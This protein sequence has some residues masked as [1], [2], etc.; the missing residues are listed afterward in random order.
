MLR[1]RE[2][3]EETKIL[4]E[5]STVYSVSVCMYVGMY[6]HIC[7]VCMSY[8]LLCEGMYVSIFV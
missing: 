2:R 8:L 5:S 6:F 7:V 1:E 4:R 3:K